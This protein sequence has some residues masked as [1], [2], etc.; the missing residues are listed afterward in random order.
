MRLW[1]KYGNFDP[2]K[3]SFMGS[4]PSFVPFDLTEKEL[5]NYRKYIYR[6]FYFRPKIIFK[7]T[8][9]LLNLRHAKKIIFSAVSFLRYVLN[10]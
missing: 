1:P 5:I 10:R 3:G 2:S 9:K 6:L 4:T 8:L 7:Y